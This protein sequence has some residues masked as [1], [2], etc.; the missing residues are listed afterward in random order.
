MKAFLQDLAGDVIIF[1]ATLTLT[2]A[3]CTKKA[4]TCGSAPRV[5]ASRAP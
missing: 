5:E 2:T 1:I 3:T 4:V